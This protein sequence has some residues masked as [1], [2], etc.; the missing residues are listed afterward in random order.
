MGRYLIHI[1]Y[2]FLGGCLMAACSSDKPDNLVPL[3]SVDAAQA[4]TRTSAY[5]S[6][7]VTPQGGKAQV[8]TLNFLYGTTEQLELKAS[9]SPFDKTVGDTLKGLLPG[10]TYYY[11]LEAGNGTSTA[12][13]NVLSFVTNPNVVPTL[14]AVSVL[15]RGP[16]SAL[17]H[18]RVT[19]NGGEQLS[20]VG[21]YYKKTGGTEEKVTAT[22]SAD[23]AYNVRVGSLEVNTTYSAQA[24]AANRIGEARSAA[25]SITTGESIVLT[26][27]GLLSETIGSDERYSFT[28]LAIAGPLNGTDL[29]FLRDMMGRDVNDNATDGRLAS[30]DLSDATI[31]AGGQ[32]YNSSRFSANDTIGY[33]L[34]KGCIYLTSLV[35]P[36]S[37][38]VIEENALKDCSALTSLKIPSS[39]VKIVPSTGCTALKAITVE[40]DNRTYGSKDGVL[41][42]KG[43]T[44]IVWFPQG[45]DDD[46]FTLPSTVTSLNKYAFEGSKL[47]SIIVPDAVQTIPYCAFANCSNLIS[48]TLGSGTLQLSQYC[49]SGSPLT[50]LHVRATVPPYATADSF[51]G[52]T[53][54][55]NTCTLY[56]PSAYKSVYRNSSVW[57]KFAKIVGE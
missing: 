9:C 51:S 57:G 28:K 21:I 23:S 3:L 11:C 19:D 46:S 17:L 40:A 8:S 12:R 24:F 27:P 20:S 34:F 16:L 53:D 56:V 45:K 29:R 39:A 15:G 22:A 1:V 52:V 13:S 41:Y 7:S 5:I 54:I 26:A 2:S 44:S 18:I 49:F 31:V 32:S 47:K 55:Y 30:L 42:D 33:G 50:Q 38:T 35:L 37:V 4:I 25:I 43:L 36:S 6:G 10:T 48:V 14:S